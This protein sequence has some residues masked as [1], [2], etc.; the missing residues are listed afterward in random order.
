MNRI[1]SLILFMALGSMLIIGCG[2]KK[3][4]E[5]LYAEAL[6]LE[7]QENF[8]EAIVIYEQLIKDYPRANIADSILFKVG[9]IYSNNLLEFEHAVDAHKRLIKKYPDSRFSAQS[10]FMIGYHYA[11][12]I[13]DTGEAR[14]YYEKFLEQ[15]PEHE[16][17]NSVRWELDHLGQDINEIDFLKSGMIEEVK[18][19]SSVSNPKNTN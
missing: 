14:N 10:L 13:S 19:D 18:Q 12:S 3:T 5:Q 17:A 7:K 8:K 4:K 6:Q 2:P 9:Q 15:Y 1:A 16:L 11:N